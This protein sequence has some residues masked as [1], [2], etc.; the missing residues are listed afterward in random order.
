MREVLR[1]K[2]VWRMRG[3]RRDLVGGSWVIWD[4][5]RWAM[6]ERG[7][8]QGLLVRRRGWVEGREGRSSSG[9]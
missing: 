1:E 8:R 2:G 4:W 5:E 6:R 3:K 7:Q 9:S